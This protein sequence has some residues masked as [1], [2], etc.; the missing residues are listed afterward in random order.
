MAGKFSQ[1]IEEFAENIRESIKVAKGYYNIAKDIEKRCLDH[2]QPSSICRNRI[3]E[4]AKRYVGDSLDT[5]LNGNELDYHQRDILKEIIAYDGLEIPRRA[6]NILKTFYTYGGRDYQEK[7]APS[8]FQPLKDV[9]FY[10]KTKDYN[11][12]NEA[13]NYAKRQLFTFYDYLSSLP[14]ILKGK[15]IKTIV[16]KIES[17]DRPFYPDE[18]IEVAEQ[19]IKESRFRWYR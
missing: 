8:I 18:L 10:L 6:I 12:A 3:I 17:S 11:N 7:I 4:L 14:Y 15:V 1:R 2:K 19:A 13:L 16:Q 9:Y 5:I